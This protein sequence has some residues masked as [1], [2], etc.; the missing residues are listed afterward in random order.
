MGDQGDQAPIPIESRVARE[1]EAG[2]ADNSAR[3]GTSSGRVVHEPSGW[4]RFAAV[5]AVVGLVVGG[6]VWALLDDEPAPSGDEEPAAD[7]SAPA[8]D[9][10]AETRRAFAEAMLQFGEVHS[11]SYRGSVHAA[12]A[13]PFG[14]GGSVVGDL[15]VEG[16]VLLQPALAREVAADGRGRTEETLTSGTTVWTRSASSAGTLDAAP[17][18]VR[19]GSR[20]GGEQAGHAAGGALDHD[21]R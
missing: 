13:Q 12:A 20:G 5:V 18:T 14:A 7:P 6:L 2:E 16:A 10:Q 1:S 8:E 17:W 4:P 9:R 21:G 3:G 15:A 19:P 11:F